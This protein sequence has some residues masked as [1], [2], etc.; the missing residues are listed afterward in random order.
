M[1]ES[2]D[3]FLSPAMQRSKRSAVWD[4]FEEPADGSVT[5]KTCNKKLTYAG[6]T[7]NLQEH[8]KRF[9]PQVL[10]AESEPSPKRQPAVT[11]FFSRSF[12]ANKVC[13][14]S[15]AAQITDKIVDWVSRDLRPLN[16]VNDDGVK[17]FMACV[18]PGYIKPS[19]T[20]ISTCMKKRH[21]EG[22]KQLQEL[23]QT[24]SWV[25]LTT[26]GWSST[27]MQSF[28]TVTCHFINSD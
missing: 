20:H 9:H 10:F 21:K 5:C 28:M 15:A 22:I 27:A 14:S 7:T 11:D 12:A 1:V 26:D 23:L 6:G 18:V 8:L 3:L 4:V 24:A 19:R 16:I 2:S 25:A 17:A 13:S